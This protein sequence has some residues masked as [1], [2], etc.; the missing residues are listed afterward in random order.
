MDRDLVEGLRRANE[1]AIALLTIMLASDRGPEAVDVV[2]NDPVY[3]EVT[4][5]MALAGIA[6]S[7]VEALAQH[8]Q[9]DPADVLQVAGLNAAN[10]ALLLEE[11][12]DENEEE[13]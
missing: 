8:L 4:T 13:R 1:A 9:I 2:Q 10:Y 5:C 12:V 7:A 6:L 3:E 11:M